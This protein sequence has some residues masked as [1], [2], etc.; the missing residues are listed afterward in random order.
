MTNAEKI[1]RMTDRELEE[2][3]RGK[4]HSCCRPN[5]SCDNR[6]TCEGCWLEWLQ[7]ES[8]NV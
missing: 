8:G 7:E 5:E 4:L 1:R 2:L 3:F 6:P